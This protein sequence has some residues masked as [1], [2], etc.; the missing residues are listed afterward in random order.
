MRKL[1]V[2]LLLSYSAIVSFGQSSIKGKIRD[3]E[4]NL[5]SVNVLLFDEDSVMMDGTVTDSLGAFVFESVA[6]AR[7]FISASMIGYTTFFSRSILAEEKNVIV[8]EIILEEEATKLKEITVRQQKQLFNQKLDRLIINMES[9]ITSSGNTILEVIQ[10][11]PGIVVNRQDNSI[12]M[13]GKSG[14]RVMINEKILQAPL[15]VVIQMLEGMSASNIEK[16]ELIATPPSKYD[17]EG[18]AGI[19]HIVTK[20]NEDFGTRGTIGLTVGHRWAET[21][22]G[23]FNINHRNKNFACF[24]DYSVVRNHNLHIMT[25]SRQSSENKFARKADVRGR[26]ENVTTQ[27]NLNAGFE[28]KLT[29]QTTMNLGFT[30][31]S[32]NWNMDALIHDT[33]RVAMDS[34]VITDMNVHQKNIW[35]SA[36]G[37]IAVRTKIDSK[38]EISLGL[39]YLYY[40]NDNPS[41]YENET[42]Y[43]LGNANETSKIELQKTTP[44]RFLIAKADYQYLASPT[45]TWEAGIKVVTSKFNNNVL[46]QRHVG[47]IWVID[48]D[49]T[50][51][52][53]LSEQ[54]AAVY[55]SSKWQPGS[56]WQIHGGLRYEYT[57]TSIGKIPNEN[58]VSRKY[59][60][61]FPSLSIQK[62]L[63][64]EKDFQFSYT[65]RISR[66]TYNDIAS[67]ATFWSPN[68]FTAEN[69]SL[70]PAISDGLRLGY[71]V[72]QWAISLQFSHVKNEISSLQPEVDHVTNTLTYRSQNLKNLNTL[73]LTNF[74]SISITPWWE[75][76][77]NLTVQ[78]QTARTSHLKNNIAWS[79]YGLNINVVNVLKLPKNFS[80][81]I[82][83]IYQSKSITGISWYLPVGSLNVGVQKD[84]GKNGAIRLAM[85]DILYT[86]N[87]R[88][89]TYSPE[90]NLDL[91]FKYNWHNQFLRLTYTRNFG[92][93]KMRSVKIKSGSEE[94]RKRVSN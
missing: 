33:N 18:N 1:L 21:L 50:S 47:D 38:T 86:N 90:N 75:L 23:N 27:Q 94:E 56:Q 89:K 32:R 49:F 45:L 88:I 37:A 85:D 73:S 10:K 22:G 58:L 44:I 55:V 74:Y 52:S 11:S 80:I 63:E 35:Q 62:D 57:T 76:Q 16:I 3:V 64:G 26:R 29:P 53:D 46:V 4:Q 59:G 9:S 20:T 61:L 48:P 39:D 34:T 82:S 40:H 19:I 41:S 2:V 79:Q 87:W 14:V 17:A 42:S 24:L 69:T 31:Y 92:N 6:P 65:R 8:P 51:Y 91:Y 15:D 70:W 68:T 43:E 71:H 93:D 66:P 81:E 5:P 30:G 83:G 13:N 36:T 78:H 60:Y 7:Y 72:K 67:Y 28:L 77:S 25:I 84:L 54:V 12:M